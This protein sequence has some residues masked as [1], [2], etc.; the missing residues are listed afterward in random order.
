MAGGREEAEEVKA[1]ALS[2]RGVGDDGLGELGGKRRASL[3]ARAAVGD[4][5]VGVTC[6]RIHCCHQTDDWVVS[7]HEGQLFGRL[8]LGPRVV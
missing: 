7:G 2:G 6:S 1:D 4:I 8:N 5:S 3:V